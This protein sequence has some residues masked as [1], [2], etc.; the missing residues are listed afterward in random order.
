MAATMA[1]LILMPRVKQRWKY[2]WRKSDWTT[3]VTNRRAA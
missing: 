1:L 2:W 3:A